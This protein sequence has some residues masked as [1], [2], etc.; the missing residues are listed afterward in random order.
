MRV[1]SIA[2][3]TR[4]ERLAQSIQQRPATVHPIQRQLAGRLQPRHLVIG[5]AWVAGHERLERTPQEP[6]P[7][8]GQERAVV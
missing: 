1:E 8:A 5:R 4:L 3:R 2:S 7:L 6:R